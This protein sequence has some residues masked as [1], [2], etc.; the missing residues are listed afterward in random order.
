M[1]LQIPQSFDCRVCY[2]FDALGGKTCSADR[3]VHQL[4]WCIGWLV[5]CLE[6]PW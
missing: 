4:V 1:E 2:V 5:S 6:N 3:D